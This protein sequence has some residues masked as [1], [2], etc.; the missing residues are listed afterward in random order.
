MAGR[1]HVGCMSQK[2]DER[3][4]FSQIFVSWLLLEATMFPP[5]CLPAQLIYSAWC[6]R[7]YPKHAATEPREQILKLEPEPET[8]VNRMGEHETQSPA[9]AGITVKQPNSAVLPEIRLPGIPAP[10]LCSYLYAKGFFGG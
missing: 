5:P 4:L 8:S 1:G 6:S 2:R 9:S 7:R 10:V 3:C